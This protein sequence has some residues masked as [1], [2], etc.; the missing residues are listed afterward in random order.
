M[1]TESINF[2]DKVVLV[3]GSSNGMGLQMSIRFAKLGAKVVIQGRDPRKMEEAAKQCTGASPFGYKP[4]QVKADMTNDSELINLVNKIIATYGKL[5]VLVNNAGVIALSPID[6]PE[7]MTKFD[8]QMSIN[9][10]APVFLASLCTPHLV[11]TK[12]NIVNISSGIGMRAFP[13]AIGYSVSKWAVMMITEGLALELGPKGVRVN[14]INPGFIENQQ[15]HDK[16]GY[17][18]EVGIAFKK[19]NPLGRNG[20]IPDIVNMVIFLASDA[21]SYV[22]GVAIPVDGGITKTIQ[23]TAF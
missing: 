10:R 2:K 16:A 7:L 9:V 5:D 8:N 15:W 1:A 6:D 12:G 21:A 11:K 23:G 13:G 17:G 18:P 22:N 3:T 19:G 20:T 14:T 4:L